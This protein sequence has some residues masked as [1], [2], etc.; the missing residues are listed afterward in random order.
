M[1]FLYADCGFVSL[2]IVE[3]VILFTFTLIGQSH[4]SAKS[5][6]R[7]TAEFNSI[8]QNPKLAYSA[9]WNGMGR[10]NETI[11]R[12]AKDN[13]CAMRRLQCALQSNNEWLTQCAMRRRHRVF[14]AKHT[15]TQA[16]VYFAHT[17]LLVRS[18]IA[19][20]WCHTIGRLIWWMTMTSIWIV[21][22]TITTYADC[23][24]T[25][26]CTCIVRFI[27]FDFLHNFLWNGSINLVRF[28][29]IFF[30]ASLLLRFK[31]TARR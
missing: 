9:K 1:D 17:R 13:E 3:L 30:S 28:V 29:H 20:L 16:H 12:Q 7:V 2:T 18:I 8:R 24:A 6:R 15:L 23:G 27:F 31:Q 22:C 14:D 4:G 5:Q 21:L 25:V 26:T 10:R 19:K 11:D